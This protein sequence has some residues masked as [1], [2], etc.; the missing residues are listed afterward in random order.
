M[1][2][3]AKWVSRSGV[4]AL[5]APWLAQSSLKPRSPS[6]TLSLMVSLTPCR[7]PRP[8][9]NR[10]AD[11]TH[12][13]KSSQKR[14]ISPTSGPQLRAEA[15]LVRPQQPSAVR[16]EIKASEFPADAGAILRGPK[17]QASPDLTRHASWYVG[18][19]LSGLEYRR[20]G[21]TKA[22]GSQSVRP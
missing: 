6:S 10:L 3:R 15:I 12:A 5:I 17:H 4:T 1:V 9:P 19:R 21:I 16:T 7:N 13:E 11:K 18:D 2:P 14:V 22:F 20:V 8:Y